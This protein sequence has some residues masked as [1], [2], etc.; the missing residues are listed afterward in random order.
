MRPDRKVLVRN[1]ACLFLLVLLFI[2]VCLINIYRTVNFGKDFLVPKGTSFTEFVATDIRWR[3]LIYYIGRQIDKV[4]LAV[5]TIYLPVDSNAYLRGLRVKG[6]WKHRLETLK[7]YCLTHIAYTTYPRKV[8]LESYKWKI[9]DRKQQRILKKY[10][11]YC[12]RIGDYTIVILTRDCKGKNACYMYFNR[13]FIVI[14]P[15]DL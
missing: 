15:K 6:R 7:Q 14:G 11:Q 1:D 8:M 2:T 9:S 3:S 12:H 4:D 10:G 13:R 5:P